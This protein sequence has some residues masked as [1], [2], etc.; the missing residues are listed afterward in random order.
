MFYY[1]NGA[2]SQVSAL[3]LYLMIQDCL[4]QI[5]SQPVHNVMF[6]I[7]Y[8]KMKVYC[9]LL[10]QPMV[11][12]TLLQPIIEEEPLRLTMDKASLFGRQSSIF[13]VEYVKI[14]LT[15]SLY[16]FSSCLVSMRMRNL[17][18]FIITVSNTITQRPV[19]ISPK[20][21]QDLQVITRIC[22]LMFMTLIRWLTCLG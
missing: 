21:L 7:A 19:P 11:T 1:I 3:K 16:Y 8:M 10:N 22:K 5:K 4:F 12:H 2:I 15:I 14:A 18:G 17:K 6:L 20:T 13:M 9:H